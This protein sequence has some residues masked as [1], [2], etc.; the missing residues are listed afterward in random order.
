MRCFLNCFDYE[1]DGRF[2]APSFNA[3]CLWSEAKTTALLHIL[4]QAEISCWTCQQLLSVKPANKKHRPNS[5]KLSCLQFKGSLHADPTGRG[6]REQI[7]IWIYTTLSAV[8]LHFSAGSRSSSVIHVVGAQ[9]VRKAP[10]ECDWGTNVLTW[11]AL[12]TAPP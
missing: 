4:G 9:S 7:H 6:R 12:V 5:S 2:S 3:S 11:R 8:K 10:C 1:H